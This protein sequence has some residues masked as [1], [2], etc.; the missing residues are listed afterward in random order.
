MHYSK[1][2]AKARASLKGNWLIAIGLFVV[3]IL[4]GSGPD[5][6][7]RPDEYDF[8][9]KD[10]AVIALSVLLIPVTLG[11]IWA[12]VD[13][14]RGRKIGFAHLLEPYKTMFGK[15]I[16]VSLLQGLFLFLWFL[17]LVIPGIIKSFS[18]MMT[19]Y[20]LR[21]EPELSPLQAI[22]KSRRMMDGHKGEAFVLGLSFIG[23]I[24][25]GIVTLFIG[26]LWI[27]P[28]IGVTYAHFYNTIREKYEEKS[29]F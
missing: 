3:S 17:L 2:R 27:I 10:A 12:W 21:D 25:L 6:I 26:F 11:L 28:Y 16:L 4:L 8:S 24:L 20:I 29:T 7:I 15:S 18:Y 19:Y 5:I 14:S 22:T 9:W 1:L 13:L 23:W